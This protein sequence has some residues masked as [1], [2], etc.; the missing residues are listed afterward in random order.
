MSLQDY[1][2][3][4]IETGIKEGVEAE[5]QAVRA[6]L[7]EQLKEEMEIKL[8]EQIKEEL[9]EQVSE[10]LREQIIEETKEQIRGELNS[11]SILILINN[12][13]SLGA[14]KEKI[15]DMLM[16]DYSLTAEE[17]KEQVLA[18]WR[19]NSMTGN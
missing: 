17:A 12:S 11:N 3:Y 5:L 2:A 18:Q 13:I 7:T 16:K 19:D 14:T 15:V 9:K 6:E 1:V 10:E 8:R 4:E